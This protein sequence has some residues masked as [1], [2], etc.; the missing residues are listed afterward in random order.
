MF[1]GDRG[2]SVGAWRGEGGVGGSIPTAS[3]CAASGPD[4][5]WWWWKCGLGCSGTGSVTCV[6][7]SSVPLASRLLD[8]MLANE[9]T[10]LTN[11]RIFVV[12]FAPCG[13]EGGVVSNVMVFESLECGRPGVVFSIMWYK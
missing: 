5:W 3:S 4:G 1:C 6:L 9:A 13:G 10:R 7:G 8:R 12:R 2:V 11:R